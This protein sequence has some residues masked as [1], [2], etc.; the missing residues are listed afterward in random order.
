[1]RALSRGASFVELFVAI[2]LSSLLIVL[3]LHEQMRYTLVIK[4]LRQTIVLDA[5]WAYVSALLRQH[6]HMA[7]YTPCGSLR[8]LITM[9]RRTGHALKPL[10][11]STALAPRLSLYHMSLPVREVEVLDSAHTLTLQEPLGVRAA[12]ILL[13]DCYHAEVHTVDS[14]QGR[15]LRVKEPWLYTYHAPMFLG[16]FSEE[17]FE[18]TPKHGLMMQHDELWPIVEGMSFEERTLHHQTRLTVHLKLPHGE[19]KS[20]TSGLRTP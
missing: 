2:F 14:I 6:L 12:V 19:E 8:H 4:K 11:F 16:V 1:M 5:Q 9:D 15:V 13:S 17:W 7:G 3:M 10:V 18:V 20:I